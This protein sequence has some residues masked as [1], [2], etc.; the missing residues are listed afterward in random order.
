M[1]VYFAPMEGLTD[2]VFR[3]VHHACFGGVTAYY[4]PFISPTQPKKLSTREKR[5][6]LPEYT[7]GVP[8]V[9]QLLAK[10]PELFLWMADMLADMGYEEVNLN[11]GCPSGT[12]TAKNKGAG[13]LRVPDQLDALLEQIC[14]RSPIPVSVKT[15]I[16]FASAEEWPELL[17]VYARYPLKKLIIHPRTCLERYDPGTVHRDAYALAAENAPWPTVFNGDLFCAADARAFADAYGAEH[18][19][20][21]GRG[22]VCNPAMAR[23]LNGGEGVRKE[24]LVRFHEELVRGLTA[25][26]TG[27]QVFMKL[28]V[29]MKHIG[30]CFED[31]ERF[32]KAIRRS[33]SLDELTDTDHRLFD[34]C[35]LKQ[36]PAYIPE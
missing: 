9:P 16:G 26:Y 32:E 10:D 1:I 21:L 5:N 36:A 29:V 12:V 25:L 11:A 13:I 6:I 7:R 4:T 28:R 8:T 27:E 18:G 14:R 17:R 33:R 22:L 24:E 23:E 19:V 15:R 3:R 2:S 35:A 31:A 34:T 30:C 20:M